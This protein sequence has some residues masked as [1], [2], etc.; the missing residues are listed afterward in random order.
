MPDQAPSGIKVLDVG[1]YLADPYCTKQLA[2]FGAQVVKVEKPDAGDPARRMGPF[3]NDEPS[4]QAIG[5]FYYPTLR[6]RNA[7]LC[8][9]EAS[10]YE[11]GSTAN[12]TP[13]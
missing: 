2:D 8:V 4:Q 9:W 5:L 10:K 13:E 6:L 1:H 7:L 11:K 12:K 3:P